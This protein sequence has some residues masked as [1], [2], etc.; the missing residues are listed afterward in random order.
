MKD[1]IINIIKN[2]YYILTG[3]LF[4]LSFPTYDVWFLK[5]YTFFA[6]FSLIPLLV[7]VRKNSFKEILFSSFIAGFIG[8]F[9]VYSWIGDFGAN[10]GGGDYVILA[11]MIP[12]L[13]VFFVTKII[14]SEYLS[15]KFERF[16]IFIYPCVWIFIDWIESIG[17][18]AF[19]WTY[20][21][22][23]QFQFIPFIQ[24]SAYT[25]IMGITFIL[26]F[27]NYIFSDF[28]FNYIQ[29]DKTL[30]KFQLIPGFK[31][32]IIFIIIISVM[33]GYGQYTLIK[34]NTGKNSDMKIAVIQS[35]IS[36]WENWNQNRFQYLE[37][38]EYYT[39]KSLQHEP[40]III[41]SESATLENI[42]YHYANGRLNEFER[43]VL[44]L[45]QSAGKPLVTGEIGV[46]ED[47]VHYRRYPQNNA[48]LIDESG[49]VVDTY[50]KIN[51]VPFGEWFPYENWFPFLK[52][53][54]Y[55]FGAS[56]FVPGRDP[57]VFNSLNRKFGVLICYEGIFY[58]L[59]RDYKNLGSE[60]LIN[61]TNLGWTEGYAGHIQQF[62]ASRFR[63]VENGIWFISASNTGITALI[64]PYGRIAGT[65]PRLEKGYLI[66]DINFDMNHNTF[67]SGY[68]DII[69]YAAMMVLLVFCF[70]LIF[71][72]FRFFAQLREK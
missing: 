28:I 56:N 20:W 36:P 2:Y 60:F 71:K 47:H 66:S 35:C 70:M 42:S 54:L 24:I 30:W 59:C 37:Y 7:Y 48:V 34:N 17:F 5:G 31:K 32:I 23:S 40:D 13:T 3:F 72:R 57:F 11:F 68:G 53:L 55:K 14:I 29:K 43:R 62:S 65:I 6:W 21:G 9:F 41:W 67:Y 26:I 39:K 46:A 27:S 44:E 63:A 25:G 1:K 16:R 22:Y 49:R 52:E 15:R 64:D 50:A 8:N 4:F 69:L 19:P 10:V 33:A 12:S 18:L 38:L 45:A 58:R 61:I 51:L